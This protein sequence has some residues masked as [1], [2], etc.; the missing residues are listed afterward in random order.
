MKRFTG[1]L[2]TIIFVAVLSSCGS[3]TPKTIDDVKG[4]ELDSGII[5]VLVPEKWYGFFGK[6]V[7]DEYEGDINPYVV[8]VYYD[9]KSD[10]D[11]LSSPGVM[12]TYYGPDTIMWEPNPD[13]YENAELMDDIVINGR[14]YKA[15]KATSLDYPIIML[16]SKEPDQIQ[17]SIWPENGK[18]KISLDDIEVQ[19]ILNSIKIK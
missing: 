12:I 19:A 2:V 11:T 17:I 13:T 9:A 5:S 16:W 14:T 15:F 7:F 4:K 18:K 1:I 3:K 10:W 6:D 8:N